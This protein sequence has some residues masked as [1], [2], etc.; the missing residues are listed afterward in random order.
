[1]LLTGVACFI[2]Y[3]VAEASLPRENRTAVDRM[4]RAPGG[5]GRRATS[6]VDPYAYVQ[7][8][9][10]DHLTNLEGARLAPRVCMLNI[11]NHR[12]EL[13]STRV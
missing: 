5:R 9:V 6:P 8:N 10:I 1:V 13:V 12:S 3:H 4:H 11:G 7:S 2:G